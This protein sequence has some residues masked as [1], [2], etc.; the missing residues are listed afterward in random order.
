MVI[1]L[2]TLP[3][4]VYLCR[5]SLLSANLK[6]SSGW[7]FKCLVTAKGKISS[8]TLEVVKRRHSPHASNTVCLCVRFQLYNKPR[9]DSTP[10]WIRVN[11]NTFSPIFPRGH[12]GSRHSTVYSII[13]WY[14]IM[15]VTEQ[16]SQELRVDLE[17]SLLTCAFLKLMRE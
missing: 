17:S 1:V 5:N 9:K 15:T 4:C 14:I 16:K 2:E 8:T 6:G 3:V 12:R 10:E 11:A 7:Q 13:H